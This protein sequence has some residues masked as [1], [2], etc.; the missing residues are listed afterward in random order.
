MVRPVYRPY[1]SLAY[2]SPPVA[3][4]IG[5][6]SAYLVIIL[7]AYPCGFLS[8]FRLF[9]YYVKVLYFNVTIITFWFLA[10]GGCV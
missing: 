5:C 4:G 2:T 1:I 3:S 10:L 6:G 9:M 8:L 7:S